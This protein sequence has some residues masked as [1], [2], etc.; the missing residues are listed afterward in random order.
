MFVSLHR[1][2]A[3]ALLTIALGCT[4][5]KTTGG[6]A[7]TGGT[8]GRSGDSFPSARVQAPP[9]IQADRSPYRFTQRPHVSHTPPRASPPPRL[10]SLPR[11]VDGYR[12][13]FTETSSVS[14]P[15]PPPRFRVP[16]ASSAGSPPGYDAWGGRGTGVAS[17]FGASKAAA[18]HAPEGETAA[19]LSAAPRGERPAEAR[20]PARTSDS[21]FGQGSTPQVPAPRV[22]GQSIYLSNDDTMSLSSAQRVIWAIENF[23]PLPREHVRPHELLNYFSFDT[24]P[25]AADHDFSVKADL[26]ETEPGTARLALAISGR[27][28][29]AS[30]RR[31]AN[32]SFVLDRS[33]SMA[34]EGRMQYLKQG[35]LRSLS[36]LGHGDIVSVTLFDA[37]ACQLAKN[38]VV[39]RDDPERLR[40]LLEAVEPRGSTNLHAGLTMGYQAADQAYQA[41]Y[42]NRVVL[43]TDAETNTGV[44]DERLIA[45]VGNYYD[46]R[47]IR[48]SG[49]GVGHTFGDALLD[50]LTERGRGAYV[51][52][53]N[54]R[55]VDA[56]FGQRFVSLIE[57]IADD[58]HFRLQLPP[59]LALRTFYGEE[60]SNEKE[61]VQAI[62]YFAGTSQVFLSDLELRE[63]PLPDDELL[64]E[65]DYE[66]PESGVG[67][68][69]SF[70]FRVS[71]IWGSSD[72][73]EKA[74]LVDAFARTLHT[75]SERPLPTRYHARPGGMDDAEAGAACIEREREAFARA[76]RISSDG[77][78]QKLRHLWR[79]FCDRYQTTAQASPP[80]PPE[81][82][83]N[84]DFAPRDSW[85][86]ASR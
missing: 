54:P 68:T 75:L 79:T 42:T 34:Q 86:S 70:V 10:T 32:L 41:A 65:V 30:T 73:L 48:L 66:D 49:I 60:A 23:E 43:I 9:R 83:R 85:P 4:P 38:F 71:E 14:H 80:L 63:P 2:T 27:S 58:V 33:G 62:H 59:A 26:F 72:N 84:N 8:D 46:R 3:P 1:L 6:P 78:V 16:S 15:V 39:G 56:I 67:R 82:L 45:E 44:V 50:R 7:S 35:L 40:A 29:S 20:R 81:Q 25:V 28:L 77:E 31:R 74:S 12:A 37:T 53:G 51:F 17:G 5:H 24:H 13:C 57:T 19:N 55:E 52:L 11:F 22:S 76:G 61:R 69:E 47:R 21:F 18:P 64:L 36:E